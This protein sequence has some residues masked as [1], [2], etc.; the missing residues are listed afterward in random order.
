[1]T[2]TPVH[3]DILIAKLA[4]YSENNFIPVLKRNTIK[5]IGVS[6]IMR[7]IVPRRERG[8]NKRRKISNVESKKKKKKKKKVKDIL[9]WKSSVKR[10]SIDPIKSVSIPGD[11]E[12]LSISMYCE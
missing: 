4:Q 2:D 7:K 12:W 11:P 10:V 1:M 8:R 6:F 3:S 5:Q 9:I